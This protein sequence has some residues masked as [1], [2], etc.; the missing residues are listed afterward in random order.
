MSTRSAATPTAG[1]ALG[2]APKGTELLRLDNASKYFG[3]V[4]ALE[5]VSMD[6]K[7]GEVHALLGDNG[8][9]NRP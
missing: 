4:I 5:D 2:S 3:T 9:G 7:A 8:A 6:L 1:T